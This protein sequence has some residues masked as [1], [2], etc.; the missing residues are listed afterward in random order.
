MAE[1]LYL[2]WSNEHR[3]WWAPEECGYVHRVSQAGR[4]GR[5]HAL[6]ICQRALGTAGHLKMLAEIQIRVE[7]VKE[8]LE[9]AFVP[10]GL[11]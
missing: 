8:F 7:D 5:G 4:Y 9:G 1:G 2:I 6:A 11:I 3:A 10:E